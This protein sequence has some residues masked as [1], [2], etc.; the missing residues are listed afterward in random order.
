MRPWILL[1]AALPLAACIESNPPVAPTDA[2]ASVAFPE[3][4]LPVFGDGYP[5]PGAPCRRVGESAQTID[6][7]DDTRDL[8]GCPEAWAGRA[9]YARSVNAEEMMRQD[10][11][12][13]YSIPRGI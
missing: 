13:L 5:E 1:F 2:Q 12:V 4:S 7:L 10:G 9:A 6:F 3:T 11:W 8:V